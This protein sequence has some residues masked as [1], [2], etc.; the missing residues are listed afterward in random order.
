MPPELD[1][2]ASA[3][4]Q[5]DSAMETLM[6]LS[7][8]LIQ[9]DLNFKML[10]DTLNGLQQTQGPE[11]ALRSA[12]SLKQPKATSLMPITLLLLVLE[13]GAMNYSLKIRKLPLHS[14]QI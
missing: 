3:P 1:S 2:T 5:L 11:N 10:K 14:F 9:P 4:F 8:T 12:H 13:Q 6:P 7:P